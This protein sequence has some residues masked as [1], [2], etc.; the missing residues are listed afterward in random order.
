[1]KSNKLKRV[2]ALIFCVTILASGISVQAEENITPSTKD[3]DIQFRDAAL[4]YVGSNKA[5]KW[6]VGDKY[7]LHYTVKKVMHDSNTQSGVYVTSDKTE[8]YPYKKGGMQY[9]VKSLIC[10]EGYTYFFRFEVTEKGLKYV[11]AK[12][13]GDKSEYFDFQK[14]TGDINTAG[15]YFGIWIGA[16]GAVSAEL[17]HVKCYDENGTDL[18]IYAPTAANLKESDIKSLKVDHS[19]SFSLRKSKPVFFGSARKTKSKTTFLEYTIKNVKIENVGQVGA[20][21]TMSP[22][23]TTAYE[24]GRGYMNYQNEAEGVPF[25]LLTEGAH[26]IV[27]FQRSEGKLETLVKRTLP[28]GKTD[29]FSLPLYYGTYSE[30]FEYVGIWIGNW[31]GGKCSVTADFSEVKCYDAKGNNLAI[32]TNQG[33]A[34]K[35]YGNLED[36]SLCQAVYYCRAKSNFINLNDDCTATIRE[37]G[38]NTEKVGSYFIRESIMHLTMND[39]TEQ[40]TYYY[41]SFVDQEENRYVRLKDAQVTF[42]SDKVGGEELEK[43]VVTAKE[44]FKVTEPSQLKENGKSFLYWS[45]GD[46]QKYDFDTVVTGPLNLY[47]V[48]DKEAAILTGIFDNDS[49][50]QSVVIVTILCTFLIAGTT[51]GIIITNRRKKDAKGKTKKHE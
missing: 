14:T 23:S 38:D 42:Y 2:L 50:A 31:K 22:N 51:V 28:T 33:V 4:A 32:Q 49:I 34:I 20:L 16:G 41:N 39:K 29:Y 46:G 19:Y 1:M 11:A 18:G 17:T 12:V 15:P 10:E 26:Y 48:W 6:E 24:T 21:I 45:T 8:T 37:D 36:Y 9:A 13:K 5:V 25:K 40:F 47:A 27:C 3:Y 7:F 30:E 44:G 35:H 43:V